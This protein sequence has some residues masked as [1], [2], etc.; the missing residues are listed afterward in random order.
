MVERSMPCSLAAERMLVS[1]AETAAKAQQD[2]QGAWFLTGVTRPR[3]R[4]SRM[5]EATVEVATVL[6]KES[7]VLVA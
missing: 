6:P 3:V 4:R 2:F 5:L 7:V 1:L